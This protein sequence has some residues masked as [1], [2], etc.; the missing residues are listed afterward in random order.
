MN[1]KDRC[2]VFDVD[3]TLSDMTHRLHNLGRTPR[4]IDE[5]REKTKND[6]PNRD[7]IWL[8]R[9][10]YVMNMNVIICTA[11]ESYVRDFTID[12]LI[13]NNVEFDDIF[14]KADNDDRDD[15][16]VKKEMLAKIREVWGEPL[17]WF[18]D[19]TKVAKAIREEGVRVLQV[20][21]GDF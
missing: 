6:R 11:R 12:W 8:S 13:E 9:L 10:F 3:G 17:F 15:T 7:I 14:M 20:A 4:G 21:N 1:I 2:V 19:R 16:V 5:F 18:D